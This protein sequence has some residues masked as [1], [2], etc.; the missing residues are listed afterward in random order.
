MTPR[1][2]EKQLAKDLKA[3][4]QNSRS[5]IHKTARKAVRIIRKNTPHAFGELQDS[6]YAAT[7]AKNNAT[8]VSAPHAQAVEVGAR[9]HLV[10]LEELIKWVKLRGMQGLT[11]SGQVVRKKQG[12]KGPTSREHARRV[13]GQLNSMVSSPNVVN[14]AGEDSSLD[15]N[16]PEQIAKAIQMAILKSGIKPQWFVLKSL[17]EIMNVLASEMQSALGSVKRHYF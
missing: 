12:W 15:I 16:A 5:A 8:I 3:L 6:I 14:F 10:P 1:E 9:P 7:S 11:N 13:A 4:R 2:F 17:P